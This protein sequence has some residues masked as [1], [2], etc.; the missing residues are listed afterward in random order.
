MKLL[1][2]DYDL[3]ANGSTHEEGIKMVNRA[4]NV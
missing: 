1:G 2:R 4:R 3:S